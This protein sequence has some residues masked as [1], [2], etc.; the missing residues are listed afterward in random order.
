[1]ID[2]VVQGVRGWKREMIVWCDSHACRTLCCSYVLLISVDLEN[3]MQSC[4]LFFL[5]RNDDD[6][7]VVE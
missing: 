7:V 2:C 1:M 3:V 4:F 6:C 5:L